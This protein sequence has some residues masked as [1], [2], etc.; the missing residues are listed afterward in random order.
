MAVDEAL[1]RGC[2][3]GI[4]PASCRLYCWKV[5]T[6][7]VGFA[8]PLRRD[9]NLEELERRGIPLVRRPTG[10]RAVLHHREITYSIICREG[11]EPLS[12][13]VSKTFLRISTGLALGLE[14]LGVRARMLPPDEREHEATGSCFAT[15]SAFELLASGKKIA[16]SAQ[17]RTGGALLQHGS[18]LLDYDP[19]ELIPLL[20]PR[21]AH[22][23]EPLECLHRERVTSV[24]RE[25]G[26]HVD[27]KRASGALAAGLEMGLGVR[28]EAGE[29]SEFERELAE[30]L[31][32]EKHANESWLWRR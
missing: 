11:T 25:T 29:L 28:L 16:G 20:L 8:Q 5:P 21:G 31:V 4:S 22:E 2:A 6:L 7:S 17:R 27:Y 26:E 30:E 1:L 3:R 32:R 19:E 12:G 23:A 10:G 13:P 24:R 9:V 15:T 18:V 14:R